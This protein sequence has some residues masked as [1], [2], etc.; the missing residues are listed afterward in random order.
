MSPGTWRWRRPAAP[1]DAA[2]RG[3]ARKVDGLRAAWL[4]ESGFWF[5]WPEFGRWQE[6]ER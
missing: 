4:R 5:Q 2:V 3:G 1:L 6:R